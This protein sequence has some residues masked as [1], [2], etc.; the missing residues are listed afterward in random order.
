MLF[1]VFLGAIGTGRELLGGSL[2]SIWF[3]LCLMTA[4][5]LCVHLTMLW[6][7]IRLARWMRL[8][9]EDAIAVG[10][11]GSQKT[12]PVGLEISAQLGLNPLPIVVYHV[13]QLLADTAIADRLRRS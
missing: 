1:V 13:G 8:S 4:A 5:V 6:T 12:V 3:E 9:R 10:F 7:G 2:S 11:S